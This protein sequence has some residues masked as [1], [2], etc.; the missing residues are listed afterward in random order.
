MINWEPSIEEMTAL[1]DHCAKFIEK[2]NIYDA[3]TVYQTDRVIENAYMFMA[4]VCDIIGYVD[5]EDE[6]D[7]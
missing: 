3:E 2:Q 1:W 7:E 4:G 6:D 5:Y